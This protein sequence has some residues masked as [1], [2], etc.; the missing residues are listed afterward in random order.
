MNKNSSRNSY[1][2]PLKTHYREDP[3]PTRYKDEQDHVP[4]PVYLALSLAETRV[5]YRR[6]GS[7]GFHPRDPDET[8]KKTDDLSSPSARMSAASDLPVH[9]PTVVSTS[10]FDSSR[11]HTKGK[12]GGRAIPSILDRD[13]SWNF[14]E[15]SQRTNRVELILIVLL[16]GMNNISW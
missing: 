10:T 15:A 8:S 12:E 3:C 13:R 9:A 4:F 14:N 2:H 6:T 7:M 5:T 16:Y 11:L 1:H